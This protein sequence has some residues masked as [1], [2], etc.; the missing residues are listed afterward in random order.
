MRTSMKPIDVYIYRLDLNVETP[1]V[2]K[3]PAEFREG[4][5][6]DKVVRWVGPNEYEVWHSKFDSCMIGVVREPFENVIELIVMRDDMTSDKALMLIQN[7][8]CEKAARIRK[9]LDMFHRGVG[10]VTEVYIRNAW[11]L[12]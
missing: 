4:S 10:A 8:C 5:Y 3:F 1:V 2:E 12:Y 7:Y 11:N 6:G 9:K